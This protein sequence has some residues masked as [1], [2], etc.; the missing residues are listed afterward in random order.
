MSYDLILLA[1]GKDFHAIDWYRNI[2]YVSP[3]LNCVYVTDL[4]SSE[5]E[6]ILLNKNDNIIKL[7]I[8]DNFLFKKRSKLGDKWRNIIK[9][10]FFPIQIFKLNKIIKNNPAAIVHAHTMYYTFLCWLIGINYISSPQGSE[11]LVRPFQSRL[12]KFF[13]IQALKKANHII[14]D[15]QN[16]KEQIYNLTGKE[17]YI[18][19]YGIDVK[20]IIEN[21]KIKDRNRIT[22]IRGIYPLYR[23]EEIFN[24]RKHS[25]SPINLSFF[26]PFH[27][28]IYKVQVFLNLQKNDD[29]FGR[30]PE[31][32]SIYD[33]LY[34]TLLAISIPISDSSPRSVAEAIFCG[35]YVAVT[36]SRW[37]DTLPE[38][39]LKRIIIINIDD[40]NWLSKTIEV[41]KLNSKNEYV[42]S[43]EAINKYDQLE[44]MSVI[45]R[46]FY[47]KH[48]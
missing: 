25:K 3:H 34:E 16:L 35:A 7:F 1:S 2:K 13:A 26:Y 28:D 21:R 31:K 47:L 36:Y 24:A 22:S 9:L 45:S 46:K 20:N 33:I 5:S 42:P 43:K 48:E 37:I 23:I 27:N 6:P 39:M 10:T 38:C 14:I 30:L 8:I 40:P 17:S 12:Y 29:D 32:S 11:I 4:I 44:T 18:I 19:Q 41:A 15:S